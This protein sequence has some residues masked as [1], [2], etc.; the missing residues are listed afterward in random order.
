MKVP[1][2]TDNTKVEEMILMKMKTMWRRM[3]T[4]IL[5]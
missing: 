3:I 5:I 1:P 2:I 4:L